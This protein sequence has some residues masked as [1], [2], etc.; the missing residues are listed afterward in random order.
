MSL[1]QMGTWVSQISI[2]LVLIRP[3]KQNTPSKQVI[4][5]G[6]F[7]LRISKQAVLMTLVTTVN[8][9]ERFN[10]QSQHLN[11]AFTSSLNIQ[12]EACRH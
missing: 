6:P 7:N 9:K 1:Q 8:T 10:A 2:I 4:S 3:T 5:T 12:S 11:V